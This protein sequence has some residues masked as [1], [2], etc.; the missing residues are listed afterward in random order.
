MSVINV[1]NIYLKQIG[2][3]NLKEFCED[4]DNIYIGRAGIVFVTTSDNKKERFPKQS[5]I[6]ANPFKI[7]K[8]NKNQDDERTNVLRGDC[9][10][11]SKYVRTI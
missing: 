7:N 8:N 9:K 4:T 3:N 5:S 10:E 2:Y 1:K 11:G 6:W